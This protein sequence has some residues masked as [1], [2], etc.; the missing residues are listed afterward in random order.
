MERKLDL[1]AGGG[2]AWGSYFPTP[3]KNTGLWRVRTD[4]KQ[5]K[6]RRKKMGLSVAY[7]TRGTFLPQEDGA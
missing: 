5:H 7:K 4:G 2:G 3:Q 6:K 1:G